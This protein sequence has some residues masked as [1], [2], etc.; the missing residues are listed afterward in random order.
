MKFRCL[1]SGSVGNCYILESKNGEQLVLDC[2]IP[3]KQF[4]K[5]N[6]FNVSDIVGVVCT[7]FHRDHSLSVKDFEKMGIEVWQPYL[8]ENKRQLKKFGCFTVQSFQVEHDGTDCVAYFIKADGHKILYATD[9][10]YLPVSFRKIGLDTL[11]VECNYCEE[12][13]NKDDFKFAH[14][15]RGHASFD[16]YL[17][18]IRDITSYSDNQCNTDTLRSVLACHLSQLGSNKDKILAETKKIV[19]KGVYVDYCR[20]GLEVDL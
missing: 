6:S 15:K 4:K 10:E 5:E 8:D 1:S 18:I 9:F 3:I 17:D 19:N 11:I 12:L 2:G 13:L 16:T 14:V 7:H 20:K